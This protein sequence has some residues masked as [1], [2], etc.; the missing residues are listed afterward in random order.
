MADTTDHQQTFADL[1]TAA[2]PAVGAFVYSLTGDADLTEDVVQETA[3]ALFRNFES[4]DR[5]RPF[6]AWCLGVARNK[7]VDR[8]RVLGRRKTV[9]QDPEVL[10]ALAGTAVDMVD[11]FEEQR[12]ALRLCL[13][14]VEG[15][16]WELL[17]LRYH[18]S[19]SPGEIAEHMELKPGHVRVLLNRVRNALRDCIQRRLS[20]EAVQR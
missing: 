9:L 18:E 13:D 2:E 5:S 4:Y 3:L 15:R 11:D 17:K 7:V 1:W 8:W 6:V 10:E 16:Q 20:R 14:G 12:L 19:L